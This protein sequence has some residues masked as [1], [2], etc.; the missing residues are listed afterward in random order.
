M[1]NTQT[2]NTTGIT[3]KQSELTSTGST[4]GAKRDTFVALAGNF[5]TVL[6]GYVSTQVGS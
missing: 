1:T 2:A 5:G 3:P 4:F 6:G